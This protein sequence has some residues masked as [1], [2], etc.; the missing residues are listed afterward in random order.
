MP[1]AISFCIPSDADHNETFLLCCR[2]LSPYPVPV[3][4]TTSR[5]ERMRLAIRAKVDKAM[6]H[7]HCRRKSETRESSGYPSI[8]RLRTPSSLFSSAEP[9]ED[10]AD[11][12]WAAVLERIHRAG[13]NIAGHEISLAEQQHCRE[14][15]ASGLRCGC[16]GPLDRGEAAS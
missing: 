10:N 11:G 15:M 3:E 16:L 2:Q 9:A 4:P 8:R 7:F 5:I 12:G 1:R 13:V 6:H 14:A